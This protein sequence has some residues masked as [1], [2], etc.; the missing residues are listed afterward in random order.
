[1]L[2]QEPVAGPSRVKP[3][4][5]NGEDG[6]N[7][8]LGASSK[9]EEAAIMIQKHYRGHQSR[10]NHPQAQLLVPLSSTFR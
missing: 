2:S 8:G 10:R 7:S 9:E 1:M 4:S 6:I 5:G 3:S